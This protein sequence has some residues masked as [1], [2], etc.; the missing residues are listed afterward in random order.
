MSDKKDYISNIANAER[1][2]FTSTLEV[3]SEDGQEYFEGYAAK[4][5]S[6]TDLGYFAEEIA[7]GAF[8][9]NLQDDVRCLYNHEP[10]LVLGRTSSGTCILSVD[11]TGLKYRSLYNP[12]DPDHVRVMEK[13]KRGD[14]SQSS[15][16]FTVE[17]E[18]WENRDG[19]TSKRTI[20]VIGQLYDVSPVTYPAYADT[21]VGARSLETLKKEHE[22]KETNDTKAIQEMERERYKRKLK[23]QTK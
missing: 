21:T 2:F 23:L 9:G 17:R 15:F 12:N 20:E 7:P 14:V 22:D 10:N 16:A 6:E 3:R 19:K 1:R 4:F 8:D 18:S 5:N 13:I 11:E